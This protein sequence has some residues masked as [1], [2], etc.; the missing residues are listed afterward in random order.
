MQTRLS[1]IARTS[2]DVV[3][4]GCQICLKDRLQMVADEG[5]DTRCRFLSLCQAI[6]FWICQDSPHVADYLL[7]PVN[8]WR[9]AIFLLEKFSTNSSNQA[10]SY[11]T[12]ISRWHL[13]GRVGE[14]AGRNSL[15]I[16]VLRRK[17]GFIS[18]S[19]W[20][21]GKIFNSLSQIKKKK[22]WLR[23]PWASL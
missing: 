23:R 2:G 4:T 16:G 11:S 14:H 8:G 5:F 12:A 13:W 7:K 3:I 22:P 6:R 20:F 21:S 18:S 17:K 19:Y 1:I 10:K 9:W 15:W